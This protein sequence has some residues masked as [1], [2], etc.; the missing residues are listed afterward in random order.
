MNYVPVIA[1]TLLFLIVLISFLLAQSLTM[2]TL[3]HLIPSL[4]LLYP[5]T[6]AQK[7]S[8]GSGTPVVDLNWYPPAPTQINNL[9]AVINGTGTYGFVF[10]SSVTPG[11]YQTYN[12]CNMPHTRSQE[13][14]VAGEE[15]RLEYVEV[16]GYCFR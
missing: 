7:Q 9:S 8:A 15:Y 14:S 11:N 2:L 12:W 16:V 10:N 13:Y 3:H 5:S 4:S 1:W 6:Y